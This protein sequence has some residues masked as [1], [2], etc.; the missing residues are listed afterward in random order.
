MQKNKLDFLNL[1]L[2]IGIVSWIFYSSGQSNNDIV[3]IE[4]DKVFD[5][6]N[7]T[8]ELKAIGGKEFDLQKSL[9]DS[10]YTKL[11]NAKDEAQ[12]K[13]LMQQL[14]NSRESL[15]HFN[16]DFA[17]QQSLKIWSRIHAYSQEFAKEKQYKM[18]VG[19]E[20]KGDVLYAEKNLDVTNELITYI[21]MKYE[22][23]K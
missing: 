1:L 11:Q 18:I 12:K 17:S 23:I 9:L 20:N 16:K 2:I 10:I 4:N 7:M 13:V 21:N 8:K 6:F 14:V 19:S 22:G 15:E 5:N 3:Y